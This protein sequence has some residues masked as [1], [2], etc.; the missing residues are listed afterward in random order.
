VN[1]SQPTLGAFRL[2]TAVPAAT[3]T[4]RSAH[5]LFRSRTGAA[6]DVRP[7]APTAAAPAA[8]LPPTQSVKAEPAAALAKR[9]LPPTLG[10]GGHANASGA[11]S[12]SKRRAVDKAPETDV[13]DQASKANA[14]D[15]VP[16]PGAEALY[17][18]PARVKQEAATEAAL[19]ADRTARSAAAPSEGAAQPAESKRD[20]SKTRNDGKPLVCLP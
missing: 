12:P 4:D 19:S 6:T 14:M 9:S 17:A 16:K 1:P 10:G 20:G 5:L 8:A 3:A 2:R 7:P 18:A 13:V 15:K 11:A